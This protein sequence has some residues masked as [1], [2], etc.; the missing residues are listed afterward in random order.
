MNTVDSARHPNFQEIQV[1]LGSNGRNHSMVRR[2]DVVP[3]VLQFIRNAESA[4][5]RPERAMKPVHVA[6]LITLLCLDGRATADHIDAGISPTAQEYCHVIRFPQGWKVPVEFGKSAAE[7][8]LIFHY[9]YRDDYEFR[10]PGLQGTKFL[11]T[12]LIHL[13]E[14]R[15]TTNRYEV[16]FSDRKAASAQSD[17]PAVAGC[18]PGASSPKRGIPHHIIWLPWQIDQL[19][20]LP[21]RQERRGVGD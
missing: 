13:P 21:T 10:V 17:R 12:G 9:D 1:Y 14:E 11:V 16:D 20:G 3:I 8:G 19:S 18:D 4:Q 5:L 6:A 7:P 15:E 2:P